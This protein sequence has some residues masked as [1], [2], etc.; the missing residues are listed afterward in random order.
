VVFPAG[1]PTGPCRFLPGRLYRQPLQTP[2]S[3]APRL[4]RPSPSSP[5]DPICSCS[6]PL[7]STLRG[8]GVGRDEMRGDTE[9]E[10]TRKTGEL[11]AGPTADPVVAWRASSA[12]AVKT[13]SETRRRAR[14]LECAGSGGACAPAA[15]GTRP[16]RK[17]PSRARWRT[18]AGGS[19][20]YAREGVSK[21]VRR[22]RRRRRCCPGLG[23]AVSPCR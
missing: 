21:S 6:F 14:A 11:D 2:A 7:L 15:T 23:T 20:V 17:T 12:P 18:A 22:A 3:V 9:G 19:L 8:G 1:R 10:G 16:A 5:F 13:D 4:S